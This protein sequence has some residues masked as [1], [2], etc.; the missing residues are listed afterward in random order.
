[1][2]WKASKGTELTKKKLA[3]EILTTEVDPNIVFCFD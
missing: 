2:G 3:E 1:M